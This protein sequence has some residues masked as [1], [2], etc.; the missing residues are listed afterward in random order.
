M[1]DVLRP[2]GAVYEETRARIVELIRDADGDA[3]VPACPSWSVRD[4]M[5]HVTGLYDDIVSGNLAGAATDEWTTAQVERRRDLTVEELLADSHDVGPKL[6]AT[7]DDF[8]GRYGNQVVADLAVHEQDIRGAVGQPGGRDSAAVSVGTE[9][10]LGAMV[11]PGAAALGLPPLEMRA[12]G[13][14]WLVGTGGPPTAD[15]E[16]AIAA[17]LA[18]PVIRVTAPP[19]ELFRALT[20]RRSATQI[21][22]FDWTAD[23]GPHLALFD[24]W[25]F[26]LRD[27]DLVE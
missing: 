9:L 18:S 15:P 6:A 10:L 24:L 26:S 21:R 23:P 4:V 8:P 13:R 20:G 2:L 19:F 5:A 25:P 22:G 14:C 27:T 11:G 17:A 3:P 16:A 12:N 1:T 7:L